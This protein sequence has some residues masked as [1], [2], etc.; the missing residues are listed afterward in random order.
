MIR[1]VGRKK[2]NHGMRTE[3]GERSKME[4]NKNTR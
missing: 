3:V 4:E 1:K 2:K